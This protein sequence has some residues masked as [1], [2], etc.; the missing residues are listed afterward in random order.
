LAE[1]RSLISSGEDAA[2]YA[3]SLD[4]VERSKTL[5]R[6]IASDGKGDLGY[7]L[8][9]DPNH[10]VVDAFGLHDSSYDGKDVDGIPHPA[11]FILDKRGRI[12]WAKVEESYKTRP[13][14][15]EIRAALDAVK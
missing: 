7:E 10:K 6:K 13:K 14:N 8:L 9:S 11:V 2:L 15:E 5:A 1:L 4:P 3:I 12:A